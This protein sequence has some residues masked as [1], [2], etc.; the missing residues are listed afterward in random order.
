MMT[1][2]R[3]YIDHLTIADVLAINYFLCNGLDPVQG[4]GV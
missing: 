3:S 2:S 4:T 1:L